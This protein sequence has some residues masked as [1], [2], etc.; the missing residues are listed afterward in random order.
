VPVSADEIEE[1]YG[2]RRIERHVQVLLATNEATIRR[3]LARIRAG[4][5]F[6][7]VADQLNPPGT[8]PPGGDI[9]FVPGGAMLEPLDSSLRHAHPG[10]LLGPLHSGDTWFLARVLEQRTRDLPP[11]A[12]QVDDVRAQLRQRKQRAIIQGALDALRASYAIQLEP[13]AGP[14][15]FV[16]MNLQE[17]AVPDTTRDTR[18]LAHYLVGADTVR[19]TLAEA[20]RDLRAGTDAPNAGQVPALERWIETQIVRRVVVAEARRWRLNEEPEI[21]R[22]IDERVN[23]EVLQSLYQTEVLDQVQVTDDELRLEYARRLQG[24]NHPP[25]EQ[26]PAQIR[27]Q[28]RSIVLENARE[29]RLRAFTDGLRGRFP[30][31]IDEAALLRVRWPVVR[32]LA[33]QAG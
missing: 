9:G 11:I 18:P 19:Y 23:N 20:L 3:A 27:E 21:A 33:P 22:R 25:F 12:P 10:E 32:P 8:V 13:G 28:L 6:S 26:M 7:I 29:A 16:R 31:T 17:G 15:L 4:E 5:S 14:E 2:W 1:F 30:V 24:P